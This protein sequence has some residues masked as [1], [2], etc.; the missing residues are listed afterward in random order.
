MAVAVANL[1]A[2]GYPPLRASLG[3]ARALTT[4]WQ[5]AVCADALGYW[6]SQ[7][8]YAAYWR[9]SDRTTQRDWQRFRAAFPDEES[10]DRLAELLRA[11][12]LGE[13]LQDPSAAFAVPWRPPAVLA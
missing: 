3:A 9:A 4:V 5:L 1:Q 6:P 12:A 10:P 7:M 2:A 13:R 11:H 8:E